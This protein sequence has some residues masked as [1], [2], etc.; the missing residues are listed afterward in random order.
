MFVGVVLPIVGLVISSEVE[1]TMV[2]ESVSLTERSS[3]S[4]I[5]MRR[6]FFRFSRM[7]S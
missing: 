7:R 3:S 4:G 2:R 1:V 5:G 6:Y